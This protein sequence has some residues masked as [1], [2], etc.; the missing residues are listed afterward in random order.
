MKRLSYPQGMSYVW[1]L[2]CWPDLTW[3]N[4]PLLGPLGKARLAQG[5]LM[6]RVEGLGF[7]LS[8]EAEARVLVEE[9]VQTATIEGERLNLLSVRSSVAR[10]L[11][12]P[13]AGLPPAG[14]SEDGLVEVLLDATTHYARPL[15]LARIKGWH[16]ALFPTGYSGLK[17]IPVGRWRRHDPM[18]VVSGPV[19]RELVHFEAPP[20]RRVM[21]EMKQFL[22]WWQKSLGKTEGILRAGLAHFRIVTIHPFEDGNGRLARVLTDMALAQDEKVANRFYS[23]SSQIVAGRD[24][25]YEVLERNQKGNGDV[26]GWLVWFVECFARAVRRSEGLLE[27]TLAKAG[28]W[29]RHAETVFGQR[30]RKVI[31]KLLDAG[32]GG[33]EGDLTTRKY[34]SMTKVSRATAYREIADLVAKKVLHPHGE[35]GRSARYTLVWD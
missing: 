31:N 30:Q 19:G 4:D 25:Y 12:L 21:R 32:P 27:T 7:N 13:T 16:A 18:Q 2:Q 6:S 35:G 8:R 20:S 24:A 10:R 33:F 14:R 23:L 11:G 28:F 9:A 34:V 5:R 17:K 3:R 22:V 26:T 29:Q 1:Q 15:S